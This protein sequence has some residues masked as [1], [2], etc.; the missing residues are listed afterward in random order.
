MFVF[1]VRKKLTVI[2]EFSLFA[3][4]GEKLK[5]FEL[6]LTSYNALYEVQYNVAILYTC[7]GCYE[8]T[9]S[10]VCTHVYSILF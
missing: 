6:T 5:A 3:F 2:Q 9:L 10:P 4:I 1:F 7:S 8:T